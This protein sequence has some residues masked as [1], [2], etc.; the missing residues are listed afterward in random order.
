MNTDQPCK[1]AEAAETL[2]ELASLTPYRQVTWDQI[3]AESLLDTKAKIKKYPVEVRR[4]LDV[5]CYYNRHDHFRSGC[6]NTKV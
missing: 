3:V 5:I 4:K 2:E 1:R 6:S